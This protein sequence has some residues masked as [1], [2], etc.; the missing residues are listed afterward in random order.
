MNNTVTYTFFFL[1]LFLFGGC[2]L[3]NLH[4]GEEVLPAPTC[5]EL[6]ADFAINN[7]PCSWPCAIRFE[8]RSVNGSSYFWEFGDG[9]SSELSDPEYSYSKP[10]NYSV[11]LLVRDENGCE[12]SIRKDA[13]VEFITFE[14]TFGGTGSENE[15]S[16]SVIQTMDGGY[17][18]A[19]VKGYLDEYDIHLLKTDAFGNLEWERTY[20]GVNDDGANAIMENSD[21]GYT[22]LGYTNSIGMGLE[23][24]YILTID[25]FGDLRDGC[26]EYTFGTQ[27]SEIG[28]SFVKTDDGGLIITGSSAGDIYLLKLGS[29][30]SK[31]WDRTIGGSELEYPTSIALA[32]DGG[33]VISGSRRLPG[34]NADSDIFLI[35]TD[36]LG[37][38]IWDKNYGSYYDIGGFLDLTEDGG[39]I[40]SGTSEG[41]NLLIKTDVNGNLEWEQRF[42]QMEYETGG[43]VLSTNDGGFV[44]LGKRQYSAFYSAIILI[45]RDAQGRSQWE[46]VIGSAGFNNP[47]AI[48]QSSDEGFIISGGTTNIPGGGETGDLYLI[49][50]DSQGNIE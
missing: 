35:K 13:I 38:L 9:N 30:F 19:G 6:I 49:K 21:G 37:N 8:N 41:E 16:H 12:K 34:M 36:F 2:K 1:L 43:L 40:L 4:E 33:F 31:E 20:G 48:R 3:D 23:D 11:K 5:E 47:N 7:S 26:C 45:K 39:Y 32:H 15:S 42:G 18:S 14:N 46:R 44:M 50:T 22:I 17:I 28:T 29:D 25:R 24:V 10:G 27:V